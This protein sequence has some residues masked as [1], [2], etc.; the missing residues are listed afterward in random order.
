M[1]FTLNS[2]VTGKKIRMETD[3]AEISGTVLTKPFIMKHFDDNIRKSADAGL[4]PLT[5]QGAVL[6]V[7]KILGPV[8][9]AELP[10]VVDM[11][12]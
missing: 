10:T 9:H 5:Q 7:K 4:V 8:Q 1:K 12:L 3:K 6:W 11:E 2:F